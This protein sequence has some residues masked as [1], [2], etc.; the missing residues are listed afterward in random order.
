M[1]NNIKLL[2]REIKECGEDYNFYPTTDE[3]INLVK[4][5]VSDYHSVNRVNGALSI[6]DCG[7]G[8]GR[9][10]KSLSC[11]GDMFA[12]EKSKVLIDS[13]GSDIFPVGTEFHETTLIDKKVDV[14]FCNPPYSEF[15][16]WAVKIIKESNCKIIYLIIP[17]RWK[18]AIEISEAIKSRDFKSSVLGSFDF[19][20]AER[21]ARAK[22]DIVKIEQVANYKQVDPF[23]IW[24]DDN[25]KLNTKDEKKFDHKDEGTLKKRMEYLI[26]GRTLISVLVELY[27]KDMETLNH[28]LKAICSLDYGILKELGVSIG[29]LSNS[30]KQRI[31]GLKNKYW[32]EFFNN[33]GMITKKLT[34]K[35]REKMLKKL[36]ENMSVDFTSENAYAITAWAIKNAN[37]YYDEQLI[38]CFER[39]IE[40]ANIKLYKSNNRTFG[41]E[42]WRYCTRPKDMGKFALELRIVLHRQGGIYDSTTYSCYD[43]N[44][45][46]DRAYEFLEDLLTISNNLGFFSFNN[47]NETGW[48]AGQ[49]NEFILHNGKVLMEVKAFKNGNMHIKFNQGFIRTL[50]IEFGRL[51]G[52]I[53]N[54]PKAMEELE[55]TAKEVNKSW[56]QQFKLLSNNV[57]VNSLFLKEKTL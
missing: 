37:I 3:I 7:S 36:S 56:G 21:S 17:Q 33:Y 45:L 24:F 57:L 54:K 52:W 20:D 14:I 31:E 50:N 18:E 41:K 10:L 51:K 25:F 15:E 8:D 9:V 12:I 19:L 11:G 35:S 4:K 39:M 34:K 29:G 53:K 16:I 1:K 2:I 38:D 43:R 42:D 48:E 13:M 46:Q 47:L 26:P 55:L 40:K 44:G 32:K 22:V 27:N 6:L 28:N 5:D 23:G 49:K 30:L